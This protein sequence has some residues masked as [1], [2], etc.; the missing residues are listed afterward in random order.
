MLIAK[1][2][3]ARRSVAGDA[4]TRAPVAGWSAVTGRRRVGA[5]RPGRRRTPP[6]VARGLLIL[7]A[8]LA[9]LAVPGAA[10]AAGRAP[11]RSLL[12][13]RQDKVVVQ[14]WD[15]SCGAAALATLLTYQYDDPVPER[16]ITRGL[17]Q[18]EEYLA[19]PTIVRTREGF[20]LLD[21]KR[22][23]DGRGYEG[24]GFGE[25]T[26]DDLVEYAPAIVPVSFNGYNHFVVFRGVVGDRVLLA[27]PA[28]GNRTMP[29]DAFT[30]SWLDSPEF[31]RVAFVVVPRDGSRPP[32]RMAPRR[33][34][35]A[36]PSDAVLR[37]T[38]R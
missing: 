27:D 25:M 3:L 34:D 15:L 9:V 5:P 20:S 38:L 29:V 12:E 22:Y 17:I 16:E 33:I 18:R 14:K 19:D 21:L 36:I 1:T 7:V 4:A 24:I 32:N 11:V 31:G 30:G 35:L 37:Q 6:A 13:M 2:P 26:F 8:S 23:V 28:F 10:S